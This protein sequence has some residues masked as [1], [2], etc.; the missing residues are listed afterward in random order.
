MGNIGVPV[1]LV[2]ELQ[3]SVSLLGPACAPAGENFQSYY[4]A[5]TSPAMEVEVVGAS[6]MSFLDN[7]FCLVCLA[8]PAGSDDPL[9]TKSVTRELMTAFFESELRNEDWPQAWLDGDELF[10]LESAGLIAAQSKNGF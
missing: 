3:N 7:P 8:C 9:V 5:A 10:G 2:G 4:S 1:T 6:H